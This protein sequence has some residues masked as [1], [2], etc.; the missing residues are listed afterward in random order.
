ML[1]IQCAGI[2]VEGGAAEARSPLVHV[3]LAGQPKEAAEAQALLQHVA[4]A[5]LKRDGVL[6]VTSRISPLDK[7]RVA[8]SL[9]RACTD[10]LQIRLRCVPVILMLRASSPTLRQLSL[11]RACICPPRDGCAVAPSLVSISICNNQQEECAVHQTTLAG[12]TTL[13]RCAV[14][15]LEA[16]CAGGLGCDAWKWG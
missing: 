16:T 13:V 4:D 11:G 5:A 15:T 9:R 8:P 6:F 3:R 10:C 14:H 1:Y 7:A 2:E 12:V